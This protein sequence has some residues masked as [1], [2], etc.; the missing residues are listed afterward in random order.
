MAAISIN[1]EL[2]FYKVLKRIVRIYVDKGSGL[3]YSVKKTF[4]NLT[5]TIT[6]WAT[7]YRTT[8]Q[9]FVLEITISFR[10]N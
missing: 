7:F 5:T 8:I 9:N 4:E 1:V 10:N 3:I 6:N 2:G